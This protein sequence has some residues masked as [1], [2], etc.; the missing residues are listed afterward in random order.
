MNNSPSKYSSRTESLEV[1][2][3][4]LKLLLEIS[5]CCGAIRDHNSSKSPLYPMA[6]F[7]WAAGK[8]QQYLCSSIYSQSSALP[9]SIAVGFP[10]A[11]NGEG[12]K[13]HSPRT[14]TA[15]NTP[16]LKVQE[17][18]TNK[19]GKLNAEV[20]VGAW[21]LSHSP[22]PKGAFLL[23]L[24]SNPTSSLFYE[25]LSAFRAAGLSRVLCGPRHDEHLGSEGLQVSSGHRHTPRNVLHGQESHGT[26]HNPSSFQPEQ[27]PH[28]PRE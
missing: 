11:A 26:G 12:S 4:G 13:R 3:T 23:P 19:S 8:E 28:A 22:T 1:P 14:G 7:S 25:P 24:P 18:H 16:S 2:A 21:F 5:L 27:L 6:A 15:H 10:P 20:C 17:A 9:P